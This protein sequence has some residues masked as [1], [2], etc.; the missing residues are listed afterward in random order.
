MTT[1]AAFH[2]LQAGRGKTKLQKRVQENHLNGVSTVFNF[3]S[4]QAE[5]TAT[6]R[7]PE[8][9]LTRLLSSKVP[10]NLKSAT[11]AHQMLVL[12]PCDAS[13]P[14]FEAVNISASVPTVTG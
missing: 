4:T 8:T 13:K 10:S 14:A 11:Q 12:A 6:F 7:G 3:S 2:P 1:D 5:F 9:S